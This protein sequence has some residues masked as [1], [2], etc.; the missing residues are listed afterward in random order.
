MASQTSNN[1]EVAS[2]I[3]SKPF[4][5]SKWPLNMIPNPIP[6]RY[7]RKLRSKLRAR[8]SPAS[9]VSSLDWSLS[10]YDSMRALRS[11]QWSLYDA[12]Y[13]VLAFLI[14]FSLCVSPSALLLKSATVFGATIILLIPMTRQF[15]L[16]FL[17]IGTWLLFF[18]TCR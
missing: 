16:P 14:I 5:Q 9:S 3:F 4:A 10:P 6:Q 11:R 15:F 1:F 2:P 17:P 18:F 12:Q 13:L 7:R 8:Q